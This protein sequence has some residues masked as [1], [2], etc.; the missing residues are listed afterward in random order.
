MPVLEVGIGV[1]YLENALGARACLFNGLG[2]PGEEEKGSNGGSRDGAGRFTP[3]TRAKGEADAGG[4]IGSSAVAASAF[5]TGE[6]DIVGSS[7]GVKA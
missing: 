2:R 4:S 6:D 5:L 3:A 7:K 1:G